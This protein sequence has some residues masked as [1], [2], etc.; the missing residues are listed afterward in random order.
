MFVW[1]VSG[2]LKM[3]DVQESGDIWEDTW[4]FKVFIITTNFYMIA[5]IQN[6]PVQ[7]PVLKRQ[8]T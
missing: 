5:P 2:N 1:I 8:F 6:T 4:V 3:L 7:V